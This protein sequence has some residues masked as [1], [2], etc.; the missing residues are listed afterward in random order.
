[1]PSPSPVIERARPLLG[2]IVAIRVG[3]LP[4]ARAHAAIDAAF[5][6]IAHIHA[7]MSF[8][9]DGSDVSRLNRAGAGEGLRIDPETY[10]VLERAQAIA[11]AS[12]GAFDPTVA[13]DLVGAGRMAAP[14]GAR[15]PDPLARWDDIL[16]EGG[17]AVRWRRPAW[18]D[19]SGIAKG[20]AV[21]RAVAALAESGAVQAYVEAGGD[22]RIL[23]GEQPVALRTG[24]SDSN[25]AV[26]RIADG[27]LASSGG[28][29]DPGMAAEGQHC[30][31]AKRRLVP[32]GRFACV[33]ARDCA[34]ADALTKVVLALGPASA[35]VLD[36]FGAMAHL[37]E[38]DGLWSALG[39]SA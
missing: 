38:P 5:G 1:M 2:T 33:V 19:L 28:R 16:L 37:R 7:R 3:G 27:S 6:R 9:D 23:G 10:A 36:R 24:F 13:G 29:P 34:V 11:R 30:D 14:E 32:T 18:I 4:A 12:R 31:G 39:G 35:T 20:H 17:G 25:V 8:Q 21:D 26:V 22:L 15:P